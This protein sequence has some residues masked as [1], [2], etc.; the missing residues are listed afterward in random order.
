VKII[1]FYHRHGALK[2]C[3]LGTPV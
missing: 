2:M 1:S 3:C